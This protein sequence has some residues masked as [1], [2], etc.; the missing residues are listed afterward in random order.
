MCLCVKRT[1]RVSERERSLCVHPPQLCG[2]PVHVCLGD[3]MNLNTT[4]DAVDSITQNYVNDVRG[5]SQAK[6]VFKI[7]SVNLRASSYCQSVFRLNAKQ[8][9]DMAHSIKNQWK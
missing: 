9:L 5:Q 4:C 3:C 6:N 7:C 1:R 2:W 8:I